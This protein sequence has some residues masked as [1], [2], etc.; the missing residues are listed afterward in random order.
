[1]TYNTNP[2]I[3]YWAWRTIAFSFFGGIIFLLLPGHQAHL[4]TWIPPFT[5]MWT[6]LFYDAEK[7]TQEE[8]P[9]PTGA[10][11]DMTA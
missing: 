2:P 11:D 10:A 6:I 8:P 4:M 5:I 9:P 7:Y 1:M 3:R